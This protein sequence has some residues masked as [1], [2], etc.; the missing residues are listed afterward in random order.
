MGSKSFEGKS[1]PI[2]V[3]K[4]VDEQNNQVFILADL[5]KDKVRLGEQIT[6]TYKLYKNPKIDIAGIDQFKMPDYKA[7]WVE[8]IF[9]PQQLKFQAQK[10]TI[11]G[12]KYQV[13][14]L[15]QRALFPMPSDQHI[16]PP[17]AL[18]IQL[19]VKKKKRRK[20]PFFDPFFNSFFI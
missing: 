14:N 10:E 8:E 1:I 13:A 15:G 11:N 7:F 2:Q 3:L 18:Q 9:T 19:E 20:D 12:V 17:I 16:V 6:L 4:S 5:D